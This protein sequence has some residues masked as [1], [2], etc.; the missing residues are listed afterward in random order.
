MRLKQTLSHLMFVIGILTLGVTQLSANDYFSSNR[1]VLDTD[2]FY[3]SNGNLGLGTT[4]PLGALDIAKTNNTEFLLNFVTTQTSSA[5]FTGF[6]FYAGNLQTIQ[7]GVISLR[8]ISSSTASVNILTLA[9]KNIGIGSFSEPLSDSNF[10]PLP[11]KG[12]LQ[13]SGNVYV[14]TSAPGI[15]PVGTIQKTDGSGA[16]FLASSKEAISFGYTSPNFQILVDGQAIQFNTNTGNAKT[17][18]ISHPNNPSLHLVH[19]MQ[20]LPESTVQYIGSAQLKKGQAIITLPGYFEALTRQ[21]GRHIRLSTID[22]FDILKIKN[23]SAKKIHN[24][25]F[26]VISNNPQSE[27]RFDWEVTAVRN[28]VP[29]LNPTPLKAEVRIKGHPPYTYIE[30]S[31]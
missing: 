13:V 20:E 25:Q 11:E 5:N 31:L 21:E 24:G 10:G 14:G 28:D 1:F 7:D 22:G 30:P 26:M 8:G 17:F 16:A 18:V 15:A 19:A 23:R 29:L 3:Y 2:A 4:S 27:Q 9:S 12:I 6:S